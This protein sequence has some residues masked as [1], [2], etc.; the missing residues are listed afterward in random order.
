[1]TRQ[2][3]CACHT[4]VTYGDH[5]RM[6]Q[7]ET[8]QAAQRT[9]P[10]PAD[11]RAVLLSEV[12]VVGD[13]KNRLVGRRRLAAL[14]VTGIAFSVL[15]AAVL[16]VASS[17]GGIPAAAASPARRAC[18]EQLTLAAP[19]G[20]LH[21]CVDYRYARDRLEVLAVA[22]SYA[23]SNGYD[24][25][26][27]TFTFRDPSS[28]RIAYQF[29]SPVVKAENVFSHNTGLI[30]LP[31]KAAD[32]RIHA[33]DVLQVSFRAANATQGTLGVQMASV[34]LTLYPLGLWCPALGPDV[35]TGESTGQC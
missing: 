14:A 21:A 32:T 6:A 7:V 3:A 30:H 35:G 9:V 8:P 25:P 11:H 31:A 29:S 34:T 4:T 24:L 2:P 27:F 10:R 5:P 20:Q 1:M 19:A 23:A 28:T 16:V 22:A 33:G 13:L 18:T 15:V 26:Y 12:F 17:P